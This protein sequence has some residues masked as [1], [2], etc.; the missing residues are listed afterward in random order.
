MRVTADT[1]I[2]ISALNYSGPPSTFLRIAAAGD[3][4]LALS[5]EIM[6][7]IAETLKRKFLWQ[8]DR[9]EEVRAVLSEITERVIPAIILDV[10]KDDPDDNK[11]LECA[12]AAHSEY[13]VTGDNHLLR[14]R[15]Y[16]GMPIVTV[17]QFL[18]QFRRNETSESD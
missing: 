15:Q 11:I 6:E 1:N 2:Y 9:I 16:D 4:R 7:E 18:S 13:I 10:V 14:L 8:P 12:Q 17:S 5:D 3:F